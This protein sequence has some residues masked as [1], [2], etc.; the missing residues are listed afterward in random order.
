MTKWFARI[1][2]IGVTILLLTGCVTSQTT[3]TIN[4]DG[5]GT[6]EMKIGFTRLVLDTLEEEGDPFADVETGIQMTPEGW[7]ANIERW[8]TDEYKGLRMEMKFANL[9]MLEDQLNSLLGPESDEGTFERFDVRQ[10]GSDVIISTQ[11][12]QE[13]MGEEEADPEMLALLEGFKVTWTVDMPSLGT[14]SEEGIAT[15]EGNRVT[16]EFPLTE[17]SRTY[18]LNVSGSLMPSGGQPE[19]MPQPMPA[20]QP[21]PMIGERCFVEVPYCISGRIGEFWEENGGLMVFG[22]PTSSQYEEIIEGKPYQVQWFE[23]NRMELH[24]EKP[25]PYDVLLGRLGV[26]MLEL[27]GI[28]WWQFPTGSDQPGCVYFAE[29]RHSVCGDFL[30]TWRA[31]GL[32]VDGNAGYSMKDNLALF[33][34][35][36]SEP[37]TEVLEDGQEHT[38]Q[39]F[40]RVRMEHHPE[41][42]AP[43]TM[44]FGLLGN[45]IK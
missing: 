39:Y 36:V 27:Q 15:R 28:D 42:D 31:H 38:V 45:E 5:S 7:E 37:M 25:R 10:D 12:V 21:E 3:T 35:P 8:E 41:N 19:P 16:W 22:F 9:E 4:P 43:Y 18:N 32:E 40:E 11:L 29:T 17:E 23:R 1:F 24:P 6:N 30:D 26:E 33:G 44:L 14:Y 13:G 34:Y 2:S 20:P